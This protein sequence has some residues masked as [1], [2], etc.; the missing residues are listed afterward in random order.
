MIRLSRSIQIQH[1]G[2][3]YQS[4]RLNSTTTA[5]PK[6][7][8]KK[9]RELHTLKDYLNMSNASRLSGEIDHL[10]CW[11]SSYSLPRMFEGHHDLHLRI[12]LCCHGTDSF[13]CR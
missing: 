1:I 8:I 5:V 10:P 7:G 9:S 3:R 2:T 13:L 11:H 12:L 4:F 6:I